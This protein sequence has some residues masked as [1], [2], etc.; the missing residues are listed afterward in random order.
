MNFIVTLEPKKLDD[1]EA[2]TTT[3]A[4]LQFGTT[5]IPDTGRLLD[6]YP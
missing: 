2:E 5:T 6:Y 1:R 4:T 3:S